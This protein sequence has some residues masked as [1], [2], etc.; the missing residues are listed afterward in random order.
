MKI[1]INGEYLNRSSILRS[2]FQD[3]S[4]RLLT[5]LL[6]ALDSLG[7]LSCGFIELLKSLGLVA[8]C[9]DLSCLGSPT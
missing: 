2:I 6:E 3:F 8:S 1:N 7:L 9:T 5:I 4:N